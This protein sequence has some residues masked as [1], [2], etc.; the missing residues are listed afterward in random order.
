MISIIIPVLNEA[1][2][3][4]TTLEQALT[5]KGDYEV[6]VVDGDSSDG[7]MAIAG[8]YARVLSSQRGRAWQMNRGAAEARGDILLFLHADTRLP[9]GAIAT[10]EQ[11]LDDPQV[12]GGRFKVSLS[13]SGWAYRLVAFS[14]N[15]RDYLFRGFTGD[16]AI[17]IRAEVFRAL[18]GFAEVPLMEDLDLSQRMCRMGKVVRIPQSVVTSS[19]RWE[20]DGVFKTIVLMWMLRLLFVLGFPASSLSR[21]YGDTR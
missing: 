10:V 8:R 14:I 11:A 18:G 17:F 12:V 13:Q 19:R 6:I 9:S 7:T 4:A 1:A 15:L 16:Q 20:K 21:F 3:I 2:T 5:Q